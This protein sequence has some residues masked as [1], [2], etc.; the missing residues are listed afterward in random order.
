[1]SGISL[2]IQGKQ[3]I[4]PVDHGFYHPPG[5]CTYREHG[6]DLRALIAAFT[7][8][9]RLVPQY[10]NAYFDRGYTYLQQDDFERAIIDFT[11]ALRL[12]PACSRSYHNRG[13]R[14]LQSKG[15]LN[16]SSPT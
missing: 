14:L 5:Q 3:E 13:Y 11:D 9:I 8:A 16:A 1:M 12:D 4:T 7:D 15:T 6:E 2:L 10:V